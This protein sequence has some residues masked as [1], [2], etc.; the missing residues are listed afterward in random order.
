MS[1]PN[2][3]LS[4]LLKELDDILVWFEEGEPDV[5]TAVAKYEQGLKTL[6]ELER[7]LKSA[8]LKVKK[9]EQKFDA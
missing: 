9:L 8:R 3:D 1:K 2:N 5:E 7:R 6:D 4:E